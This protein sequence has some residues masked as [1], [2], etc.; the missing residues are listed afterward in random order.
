MSPVG[1]R[2]ARIDADVHFRAERSKP[3]ADDYTRPTRSVHIL[4]GF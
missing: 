3:E 1:I 4:L 2:H